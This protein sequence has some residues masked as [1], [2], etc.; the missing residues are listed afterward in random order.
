MSSSRA[1][2][3]KVSSPTSIPHVVTR[4][5]S[6]G[7]RLGIGF[8]NGKYDRGIGVTKLDRRVISIG[9]LST[10][11][12]GKT[13]MVHWVARQLM[14]AGKNPVIAMRGYR[15]PLGEMGDEERE[16]REALPGVAVVAQP[17]RIAGLEKLFARDEQVDCVIL[18][19]GFQHRK[20][21]R[22]IDIVLIDASSPPYCDALLPRGFLREPISSLARADAV[23][24]THREMVNDEQLDEL[25][26]WV[27]GHA[28]GC[29]IGV[30]SHVWESV[31]VFTLKKNEWEHEERTIGQIAEIRLIGACAIGNPD[32]F[33]DQI[34]RVGWEMVDQ[35]SLRDH[36]SF[37]PDV[38]SQI[39]QSLKN[40]GGEAVCMTRKDW[41]KAREDC[42]WT[43]GVEVV[44]PQLG[45]RFED[46]QESVFSHLL[47]I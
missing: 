39:A 12:T 25:V 5:L 38:V 45:I 31:S 9:N 18:D 8:E 44:V 41:M 3:T 11:G 34:H 46:G 10:G 43:S 29:Q 6:W 23:V 47:V 7:Y 32:G 33:F 4:M 24:I 2:R 40:K 42:N 26:R 36:D 22:D 15:A 19:D 30:S 16:H 35:I 17:D 27:K 28:P 20:I 37:G 21:A 14:A 13:P 1:P